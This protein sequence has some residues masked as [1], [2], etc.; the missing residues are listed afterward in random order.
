MLAIFLR[1]IVI[2]CRLEYWL[3]KI[4]Q[5]WNRLWRKKAS[6][7][8]YTS[9]WC[10]G[11]LLFEY[12][13]SFIAFFCFCF[14]NSSLMQFMTL[15]STTLSFIIFIEINEK[16]HKIGGSKVAFCKRIT[17]LA[18][19]AV[20]LYGLHGRWPPFLC[21]YSQRGP[22]LTMKAHPKFDESI[23]LWHFINRPLI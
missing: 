16:V 17:L 5:Y 15:D 22:Y 14:W 19:L 11:W 9:I 21:L 18:T 10:Y 8:Y 6:Y 2:L 7:A 13:C 3:S 12:L 23:A 1:S 4:V 20:H